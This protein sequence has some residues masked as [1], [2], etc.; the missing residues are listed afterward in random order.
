VRQRAAEVDLEQRRRVEVPL[1]RHQRV[2]LPEPAHG[3]APGQHPGAAAGVQEGLGRALDGHAR[4]HRAEDRL[5]QTLGGV[6]VAGARLG[7]SPRLLVQA[8]A[9][10]RPQRPR[11]VRQVAPARQVGRAALEEGEVAHGARGVVARRVQQGDDQRRAHDAAVGAHRVVDDDEAPPR[12]VGAQ[13]QA[14]GDPGLGEAPARDL[15]H[16]APDER[17]DGAPA[18]PL[19]DAEAPGHAAALGQRVRQLLEAVD[20]GDL[21]DEVGLAV[22][23]VAAEVRH[24]DV[25]A[26]GGVGHPELKRAQD[27]G[28]ARARDGAAED[29]LD[30][31]L[32]QADDR[33]RTPPGA[34]DVDGAGDEPRAHQLEHELGGD[35]LPLHGLLGGHPLLEAVGGLGAQP[36]RLR[37]AVD[38]RAVPVGR[39]HEHARRPLAHLRALAAHDPGDRGRPVGVLDDEHLAVERAHLAVERGDPLALA[40][41][42]DD[43]PPA[44]HAVEVEG[45]QRLAGQEHRVVRDV[46]DVVDRA[47]AGGHQPRLQPLRRR[48]DRHALERACGEA[49]VEVRSLDADLDARD[50]ARGAGIV[51]PRRGRQWRAGGRVGL[52]R[53]PVD[54]QAV[55]PVGR[56]LELEDLG[57]DR[58]HVGERGARREPAVEDHDAGVLGA[59]GDLVLG[60]DHPVGLDAAQLGDPELRAVGQHRPRPGHRDDLT[61]RDVGRAADDLLRPAVA[62]VDRAHG[63]AIGVGV[64]RG[65]EHA[66]DDEA[67]ELAHAVMV[68]GLDLR[69]GHCQALLEQPGRQP[70]V[71]VLLQPFQGDAHQ[72]NCSRK[73]RSLSQKTRRSV[74]PCLSMAMRSMP[75]PQA[76]PWTFSG[77]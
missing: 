73:R 52:A 60:E 26:A 49:R 7:R 68:D 15:V 69:A 71:H 16:P 36:Q 18:Q 45:V 1:A 53:D 65:L 22:D 50:V 24:G 31:G 5:E 28:L 74:T 72:P 29:R 3:L 77:S 13:A 19:L 61:G 66:P 17:V 32:A 20:A 39:L 21:L 8:P 56:D 25:E 48:A 33:I 59:D 42:A 38:V 67:L 54:R 46:D 57:G 47:L 4:A 11:L 34:P 70:R 12:I 6:E 35:D 64:A 43:E 37:R 44:G 40:R 58:Q 27:L 51:G 30:L 10:N 76:K 62:H 63:Q 75:I 14:V 23:V 41:A 55:G 9:Q 2:E